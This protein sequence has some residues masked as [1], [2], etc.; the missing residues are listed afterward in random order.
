VLPSGLR[1]I[2]S[3]EMY[4][5]IVELGNFFRELCA[6]TLRAAVL[7]RMKV[8]IVI[9]LCKLEL[10]FPPS[11]FD[12][13]VHLAIHL[14]DEAL[15]RGPVQYGW[16]YPVE[17]R[18]GYLKSTMH[19]KSRPEGSIVEGYIVDECLHHCSKFLGDVIETRHNKPKRNQ[20]KKRRVDPL[21]FDI[22]SDGARGLGLSKLKYFPEEF[23]SMVWYVLQNYDEAQTYIR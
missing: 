22:F 21:E 3:K 6:K 11:F 14:P 4:E 8:E 20:D 19:S 16:M 15:Q 23:D 17:R 12:V 5:T 2:A 1:G 13:M 7:H 9:I 18:L 10:L